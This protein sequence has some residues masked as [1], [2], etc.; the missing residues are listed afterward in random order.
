MNNEIIGRFWSPR[1]FQYIMYTIVKNL[2]ISYPY[3]CLFVPSAQKACDGKKF[4]L[5]NLT[6]TDVK[7]Q[8]GSFMK[9]NNSVWHRID[10]K[11][12]ERIC[13][14]DQTKLP[15]IRLGPYNVR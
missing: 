15:F 5:L 13:K 14:W 6:E 10:Q 4:K 8:D 2:S 9:T 12:A 3:Q 11:T 7:T 1:D